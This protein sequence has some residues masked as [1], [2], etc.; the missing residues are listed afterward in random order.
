[1]NNKG[2]ALVEFI[3]I[4]PIMLFLIIGMTDIGNVLIKKHHLENDLNYIVELY[5]NDNHILIEEY[6][7][8]KNIDIKIT[9]IDEFT[10]IEVSSNVDINTPFINLAIKNPLLIKTSMTI[11][12]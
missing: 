1:M 5:Q 9:K 3:L 6:K 7:H 2:Q 10:T 8:K 12:G 11:K 4:L